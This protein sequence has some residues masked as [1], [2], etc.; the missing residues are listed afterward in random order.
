MSMRNSVAGAI[1]L[2]ASVAAFG[3]AYEDMI[4]AMAI[5][6]DRTVAALL[7]R[8]MDADTAVPPDG[9]TLLMLAAKS[10]KPAMVQAVLA[11]RP[12]VNARNRHGETA[13]MKAAFHGHIE[14]VRLLLERGAEVNHGGWTPLIYA[15]TRSH[16]E[17]ARLLLGKGAQ[18]NAQSPSG[19][20]ALMMAAREGHLAMVL[21]LM[22]HGADLGLQNEDGLTA[23]KLAQDRGQRD[24]ANMLIRAG[25]KE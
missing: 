2:S 1:L 3:G 4:Q 18:V 10:G 6:D 5:D 16:V 15:A 9:D 17:I 24:I 21:L 22:E 7:K 8:G 23:L 11:A 14:A 12:K 19:I 13:L 20:S 25:A